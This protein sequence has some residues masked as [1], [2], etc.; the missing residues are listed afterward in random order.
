MF[1]YMKHCGGRWFAEHESDM[2]TAVA[3][4][5][6]AMSARGQKG[7]LVTFKAWFKKAQVLKAQNV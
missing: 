2:S 1:W 3:L 5:E 6:S 7:G 4:K